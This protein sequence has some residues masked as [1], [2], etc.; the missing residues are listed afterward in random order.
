MRIRRIEL[1]GFKSFVERTTLQLGPGISGVV[2]PNGC[3]KSNVIDAIKWTLGE[4]SPSTLRGQKMKDVIFA[5]AEGRRPSASA[6]VTIAFD[7]SDGS[8]GGKYAR[9]QEIEV[10]R[11]L[12]R[13]GNSDYLLNRASCRRKDIVE[14]FLDTGVGARAY[15]IIEQGRVDFVINARPEERRVLIDE[16]A[17][18]NRFKVQRAEAER[19]MARTRENLVRVA[20]LMSEMGRQRRSLQAQ[21]D[22]ARKYRDLRAEWRQAAL[23]ALLGAGL[24]HRERLRGTGGSLEELKAAEAAATKALDVAS[25]ESAA[26]R[27]RSS[28]ARRAHE[29]LRDRRGSADAKRQLRAKEAQLRTEELQSVGQRLSRLDEELGE[30]GKRNRTSARELDKARVRV[31]AARDGLASREAAL[32]AAASEEALLRQASKRAHAEVESAKARQLAVMAEA[33]RKANLA[34]LLKRRI[35][36]S[37]E[38]LAGQAAKI[39]GERAQQ[40]ALESSVAVAET[41]LSAAGVRRGEL[42]EALLASKE[43]T[44]AARGSAKAAGGALRADRDAHAGARARLRSLTELIEGLEGFGDGPREAAER[45]GESVLGTVADLV[46][47]SEEHEAA[48]ELALGDCLQGLVVHDVAA[49]AVALG[50]LAGRVLLVPSDGP[51]PLPDSLAAAVTVPPGLEGVVGRLLNRARPGPVDGSVHVASGLRLGPP[52]AG[53]GLLAQRRAARDLA[54]EVETRAAAVKA[55]ETALASAEEAV[56]EADARQAAAAAAGHEAELAELTGRRDLDAARGARDRAAAAIAQADQERAR[57]EGTLATAAEELVGVEGAIADAERSGATQDAIIEGAR[58]AAGVAEERFEAASLASTDARIALASA[59]QTAAT[60]QRDLRRL[61]QDTDD[62]NRRLH[63]LQSDQQTAQARRTHLQDRIESLTREHDELVAELETLGTEVEAAAAA[64][65]ETSRQWQA[66]EEGL[67]G[68]RS[69]V[70][71]VRRELGAGEVVAAEARTALAGVRARAAE[72]FDLDVDPVLAEL[73]ASGSVTV[74][75]KGDDAIVVREGRLV[76]EGALERLQQ[77]ATVL[78][79][80]IDGLGPVNLAADAEFQEVDQRYREVEAQ[81][82]DLETALADLKRAIAKIQHETRERFEEAFGQVGARFSALYPRLVGGGRAELH[83]TDPSDLLGTGIDIVVEPP[84]KRLQNLTLLSG[85]EKAMA[86]IALVFAIF[87][88]KPSP[89]CLLDEVDA[90]LD[91]ANS[92]RMGEMLREMAA[93]TQ[94]IVITHNRATMEIADVLYGVTMQRPG[95]SSVVSVRMD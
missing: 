57:L 36:E 29:E 59:Q 75:L 93:E 94:F 95:V 42:A 72:Q 4:Q 77:R 1:R 5:G 34:G 66:A 78:G 81:K 46:T 12:F 21:A 20:D 92:R 85:G 39:E 15:S 25:G 48:V 18:I 23:G 26:L 16:V 22:R 76:G 54:G 51:A 41:A 3:G 8:F 49:A 27:E 19:R 28:S 88:V 64:R 58:A 14:L 90:P 33:A 45:L 65:E 87:Q 70:D 62:A 10:G 84:G 53:P 30:L 38:Q 40:A 44:T 73:A 74:E 89:F 71:R 52:D 35:A 37:T 68:L 7:N 86:A 11:R 55:S 43:A 91:D 63:R 56:T 60:V 17:G 80:K 82:T 32:G 67:R 61:E 47:A 83:L 24:G 79:V 6:E 50:G 9:F 69:E 31:T 13:D 2:G